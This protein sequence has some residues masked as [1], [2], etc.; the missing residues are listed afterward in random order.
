VRAAI[1]M[2]Q[3]DA[4]KAIEVLQPAA[5]YELGGP[6]Y[7][8]STMYPAFLRGEAHL[9][10]KQ[11]KEAAAEF[12]KILDHPGVVANLSTGA[13]ARLGLARAYALEGD[14][15]KA[16]AAYKDF[17]N[18]WKDADSDVPVLIQAKAEYAKLP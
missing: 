8:S 10:L 2:Q 4:A 12:Q 13:L 1:A 5:A 11:G 16:K 15:A 3:H 9:Q 6:G 7:F 14:T 17:L 18:L